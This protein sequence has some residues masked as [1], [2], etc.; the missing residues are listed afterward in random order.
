MMLGDATT[1]LGVRLTDYQREKLKYL[2]DKDGIKEVDYVRNLINKAI[3]N[4]FIRDT[5]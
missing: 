2:A 1:V 3:E 4:E 5:Q